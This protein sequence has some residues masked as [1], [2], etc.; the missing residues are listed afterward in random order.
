MNC[1]FCHECVLSSHSKNI[2]QAT[3]KISSSDGRHIELQAEIQCCQRLNTPPVNLEIFTSH[4]HTTAVVAI[5]KECHSYFGSLNLFM[6]RQ[7]GF[8][9]STPSLDGYSKGSNDT[10]K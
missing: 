3:H 1:Y 10:C 9:G 7:H 6:F 4:G 2:I 5:C 8:L